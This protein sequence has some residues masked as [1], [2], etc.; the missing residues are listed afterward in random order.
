MFYLIHSINVNH[1]KVY[2]S[3]ALNITTVSRIFSTSQMETLC[4][5]SSPTLSPALGNLY[6]ISVSMNLPL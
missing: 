4:P 2:N 1:F 6:S 3:V 5:L